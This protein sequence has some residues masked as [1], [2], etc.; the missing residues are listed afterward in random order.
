[1]Q[2]HPDRAAPDCGWFHLSP[3]PDRPLRFG[4][5]LY[6]AGLI[7]WHTMIDAITWQLNVRPKIGEIGRA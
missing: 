5:F 7:D 6:Y 4:Q 1:M 2:L 3:I